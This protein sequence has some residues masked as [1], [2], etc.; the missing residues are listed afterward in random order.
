MTVS[1]VSPLSTCSGRVLP[2]TVLTNNCNIGKKLMSFAFLS[3]STKEVAYFSVLS[4]SL[5]S[6]HFSILGKS[7]H[8]LE[9]WLTL[10]SE[11]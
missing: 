5:R 1:T 8:S 6:S 7:L 10:W 11:F 4:I 9:W 3:I 2:D